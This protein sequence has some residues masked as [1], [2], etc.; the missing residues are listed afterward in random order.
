MRR[1]L[2]AALV[3]AAL[4]LSACGGGSTDAT[5]A[6]DDTPTPTAEAVR[7]SEQV[8]TNFLDSCIENAKETAGGSASDEVLTQTCACI[9]GRVEQE[10]TESEFAEFEK[11]LLGGTASDQES[12][13]LTDWST[14]CAEEATG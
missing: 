13:Q 5:A 6:R 12:G 8:R 4:L 7:F 11:R 14:D 1:A 10:Y 3:P 2:T 9:L